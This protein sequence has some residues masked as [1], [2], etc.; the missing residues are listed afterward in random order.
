MSYIRFSL[1]TASK[2]VKILS[3]IIKTVNILDGKKIK[4]TNAIKFF[5]RLFFFGCFLLRNMNNI[6]WTSMHYFLYLDF[7]KTLKF[8]ITFH[9]KLESFICIESSDR[10]RV[11]QHRKSIPN[12]FIKFAKGPIWPTAIE[13]SV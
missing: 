12:V 8:V 13:D 2:K 10:T 9:G 11:V 6:L 7:N 1:Q 5:L 3:I 4:L